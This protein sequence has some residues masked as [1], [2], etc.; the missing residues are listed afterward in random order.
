[1]ASGTAEVTP[2]HTMQR[3]VLVGAD[4]DQRIQT[5]AKEAEAEPQSVV[6]LP[7][8]AQV[9][10]DPLAALRGVAGWAVDYVT[11]LLEP[12]DQLQG[13]QPSVQATV[14]AIRSTAE[15]MR[16]LA[17]TQRETLAKPEGWTGKARDAYQAS[18]E[19]L[20]DE[21]DSLANA[22]AAKGVVVENTGAMVRAL[23]EAL[24]YTVDQYSNSLVPGAIFAYAFAPATF[25]V[26]IAMFLA[27]VVDSAKQLGTAMAAKMDA[28]NAALTRQVDR[29]KML[30]TISDEVAQGW[31]RFEAAAGGTA[32]RVARTAS[33]PVMSER[34]TVQAEPMMAAQRVTAQA[35]PAMMAQRE[36]AVQ[37][38]PAMMAQRDHVV[39][40]EPAMMR[41]T[42]AV[43]PMEARRLLTA[44]ETVQAQHAV[45]AEHTVQ[46]RHAV[47]AEHVV[48][49]QPAMQAEHLVQATR[50]EA[51]LYRQMEPLQ[52]TRAEAP[53]Y[54]EMEPLQATRAE[55]PLYRE[56]QPLQAAYAETPVAQYQP[57]ERA[58]ARRVDE[59]E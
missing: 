48:Q 4:V 49:A 9:P 36:H 26:S 43:Q 52:A 32:T 23:R 19:G 10:A 2:T 29:I 57:A 3:K 58:T 17:S 28:L 50:A 15:R 41:T 14:D 31:E 40:A 18:M 12:I 11:F 13:D 38:Q 25:G 47:Q 39:Q 5:I 6:G 21:L 24:L 51:P 16:E 37:A 46:A 1:M 27:S 53:V 8:G 42:E 45:R 55:A 20:G 56:V 35:E 22:V 33:R 30:D 7:T 54:R 34:D 59:V 44:E